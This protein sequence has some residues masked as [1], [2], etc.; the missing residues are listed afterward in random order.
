MLPYHRRKYWQ[1]LTADG[2]RARCTHYFFHFTYCYDENAK[3]LP[4]YLGN[5]DPACARLMHV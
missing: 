5:M 3:S 2:C 4:D 1:G